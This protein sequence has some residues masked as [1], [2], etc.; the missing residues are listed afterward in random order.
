MRKAIAAACAAAFVA[1][2][3][4]MAAEDY[5]SRSITILVPFAA[6]GIVDIA[7]RTVGEHLSQRWGQ[8][9]IVENR[10]GGAG[11][12]AATAAAR[13]D[14]DGYTLLMAE[15]GVSAINPS[16]FDDVP[17]DMERDFIPITTVSDTPLVLVARADAPFDSTQ[18]FIA[19]A[20]ENPGELSFASAGIGT[21]NHIA[22]EWIALEAGI[23]LRAI[24]YRGG[25]PAATAIAGGEADVG[26]LALSSVHPFV[27]SGDMK[28]LSVA[29]ERPADSHPDI[30]TIQ[31]EGVA[32]IDTSQW[33]GLFAPSGVPEE[34]VDKL[35]SEITDILQSE[36]V[37]AQFA[38]RGAEAIPME[39]EEF[40]DM[41]RRLSEQYRV[42]VET[43]EIT[44]E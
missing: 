39:R 15:S 10:T 9:V 6:G 30:P 42:I 35:H 32:N 3:S 11:F 43:A 25:P 20:K 7:A 17:Y 40:A 8:E 44:A 33:A 13:A 19:Y 41:I 27:E 14:P 2:G 22:P 31:D 1:A 29:R 37:Q 16:L 12:I 28:I 5:P 38:E 4:A 26:V 23:E 21:L 34:I 24:H 18:E 36:E